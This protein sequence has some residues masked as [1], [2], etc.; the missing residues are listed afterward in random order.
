[1]VFYSALLT[2]FL[3]KIGGL[4]LEIGSNALNVVEKDCCGTT[5]CYSSTDNT[6]SNYTN[7]LGY[8][9]EELQSVHEGSNMGLGCGNPQ[10]I[11]NIKPEEAVLDLGS[12]GGF[13]CFLAAR[14]VGE[15]GRFI[16]VDMT[17][18]MISK[19]R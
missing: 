14:K 10:A 1:M 12:G 13:D 15:S 17:P 18:E 16:G 7:K 11:A 5:D 6:L 9:N 4:K 3:I 8:T 19:A 2:K